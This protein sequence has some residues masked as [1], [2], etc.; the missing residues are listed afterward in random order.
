L[1]TSAVPDEPPATGADDVFANERPRLLGL[2]YRILG[3]FGDAEDVVQEAW[4]RWSAMDH[5]AVEVPEAFLTTV[6]T[7][8]A[9]DRFRVIE[10]RREQYVGPWLPE[11]VSLARGPE[12]HVELAE[13]LTLGFLLVLD[14]LSPSE[15]AVWLLADVFGEPYAV[16]ADAVGKTPAACRQMASRARRRL[17]DGRPPP[18]EGLDAGLLGRLLAAV[19]TGDVEK[20]LELL[21]VDVVLLSDGGPDRHAARRPV[22]GAKR[23]A[24]FITNIARRYPNADVELTEING[25]AAIVLRSSGLTVAMTGEQQGG[26]VARI[27]IMMNSDKLHALSE[28][29]PQ[30]T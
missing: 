10:R 18:S 23:V 20:T 14:R 5:G 4:L 3:S 1:W 24:R 27:F 2:A 28:F 16:I 11:P 13:S 25:A 6:T 19:A 7:R 29:P 12:E 30:M 22:V 8:L 15:R 21:D 9:L 17:H 26:K